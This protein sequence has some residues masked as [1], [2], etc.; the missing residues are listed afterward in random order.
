VSV[1]TITWIWKMGKGQKKKNQGKKWQKQQKH[2]FLPT[3]MQ[4]GCLRGAVSKI[5]IPQ[6]Q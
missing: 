1:A 5:P 6:L 2:A 4:S 3:G